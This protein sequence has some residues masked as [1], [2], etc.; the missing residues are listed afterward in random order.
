MII[1]AS[2][3]GHE[4]TVSEPPVM[5]E[6]SVEAYEVFIESEDGRS[7][8]HNRV[9]GT[10]QSVDIS[11]WEYGRYRLFVGAIPEGATNED[12][13]VWNS[14]VFGISGDE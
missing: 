8:N 14:M 13:I 5:A 2:L 12:D 3:V 9:E 4:L 10:S 1:E 7:T 6:G 11:G